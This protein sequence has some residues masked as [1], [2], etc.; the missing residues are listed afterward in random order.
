MSRRINEYESRGDRWEELKDDDERPRERRRRPIREKDA[1]VTTL[2]EGDGFAVVFKPSGVLTIPGRRPEPHPTVLEQIHDLWLESDPVAAPPVVCHRLDRDTSGCLVV[3]RDR[4]TAREIMTR[5][6]HRQ[7][8]KSYLALVT[9]APYPTEGQV[10]FRVA[11]DRKRPGTMWTPRKGGK[12]CH[13]DYETVEIFRGVSLV[14]V[15][16]RTGRTHEVRLALKTLGTPCAIDPL[17]GTPEPILLSTW[18]RGYRVG[19]GREERPL[20]DRLTLHAESIQFPPP[21]ADAEDRDA[22]IR[23]EAPLPKDL[24]TTLTQL[25]KHAAPGSL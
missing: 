24:A 10:D 25:R 21:G 23:V 8:E 6:R 18:K 3:A 20:I 15:F 19:R 14:R 12:P 2:F 9:G 17:Y 11:P 4:P 16:P 1:R 5:F 22:W 7:V 13:D